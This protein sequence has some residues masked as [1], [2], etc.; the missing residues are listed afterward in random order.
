MDRSTRLSP[1]RIYVTAITLV[2]LSTGAAVPA[3]AAPGEPTT[4]VDII[5]L[6]L[7]MSNTEVSRILQGYN[8]RMRITQ[9]VKKVVVKERGGRNL[10]IGTF[11]GEVDADVGAHTLG[12]NPATDPVESISV[13]FAAP[14]SVH[15]VVGVSRSVT[16][17]YGKGPDHQTLMSMLQQKYGA[18]TQR[19]NRPVNV[20]LWQ[21]SSSRLTAQ[22][23]S[24]WS[25]DFLGRKLNVAGNESSFH[26]LPELQPLIP[27]DGK[28]G[29][30]Y[31]GN[32][33]V[34]YTGKSLG[35]MVSK[36]AGGVHE[37]RAVLT[38]DRMQF[39]QRRQQ[40]WRLAQDTLQQHIE[41][42]G[43]KREGI[44]QPRL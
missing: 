33:P 23:F 10:H 41:G 1:L 9:R 11:V 3:R 32:K 13:T 31:F 35:I 26:I 38:E 4:N 36:I 43:L 8:S 15:Q 16:Y 22:Q 44:T 14:P 42:Q 30:L 25:A 37:Y 17:P 28:D 29:Y 19:K 24:R 5:G 12:F 39:W 18:P 21:Y 2:C 27:R 40:E 6:Q 20:Q 7:G 34:L